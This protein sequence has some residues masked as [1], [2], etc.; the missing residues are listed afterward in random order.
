MS[1]ETVMNIVDMVVSIAVAIFV[2]VQASSARKSAREAEKYVEMLRNS[3]GE[4][5]SSMSR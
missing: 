5:S 3:T 4:D 2:F 1:V